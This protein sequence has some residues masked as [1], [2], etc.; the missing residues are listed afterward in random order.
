[1]AKKILI[2]DDDKLILESLAAMLRGAGH[3]VL[4]AGNGEEG[5]SLALEQHPDLVVTDVRMPVKD[6]LAM[7]DDLRA[8]EWGKTVPIIVLTNDEGTAT[9]NHA[10]Q[11]GVTVYLSKVNLDPEVLSQQ[12]LMALG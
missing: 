11:A 8:D 6:G 12:V 5:V 3:E 7:I 1:M 2:V 4:Q 10:L 9:V